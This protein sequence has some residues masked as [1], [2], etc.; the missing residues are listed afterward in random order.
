MNLGIYADKSPTGRWKIR[1][2]LRLDTNGTAHYVVLLKNGTWSKTKTGQL[3]TL[4]DYT[5]VIDKPT[6]EFLSNS[7]FTPNMILARWARNEDLKALA[8]NLLLKDRQHA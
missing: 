8:D 5:W 6:W 1:I 2:L 3:R 7:G 4:L